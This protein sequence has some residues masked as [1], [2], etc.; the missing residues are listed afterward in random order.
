MSDFLQ[1]L[2]A[3]SLST[4]AKASL[5]KLYEAVGNTPALREA[6]S[7]AFQA[8][9]EETAQNSGIN[10]ADDPGLAQITQDYEQD[11]AVLTASF[12]ATVEDQVAKTQ[13]AIHGL[14]PELDEAMAAKIRAGLS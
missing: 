6:V 2:Q 11:M 1:K 8:Q 13:A 7:Q 4:E 3:T 5:Q 9:I 10:L 12:Q 14:Q